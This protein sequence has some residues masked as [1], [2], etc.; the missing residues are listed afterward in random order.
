MNPVASELDGIRRISTADA[1][2]NLTFAR[3]FPRLTIVSDLLNPNGFSG[4]KL[5]PNYNRRMGTKCIARRHTRNRPHLAG[6]VDPRT[7]EAALDWIA[8]AP[9]RRSVG[10]WMDRRLERA[11]GLDRERNRRDRQLRAEVTT[12]VRAILQSIARLEPGCEPVQ[13]A[14]L[15]AQAR[16]AARA[17]IARISVRETPG[18]APEYEI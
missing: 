11:E 17:V 3:S 7:R 6:T 4:P 12:Q 2:R 5:I 18:Q 15:I 1:G 9:S 8:R 16:N 10:L 13:R 14:V